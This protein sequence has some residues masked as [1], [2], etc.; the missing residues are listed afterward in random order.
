MNKT[1]RLQVLRK[2]KAT[3]DAARAV[4][5]EA[6]AARTAAARVTRAANKEARLQAI[7]AGKAPRGS[8]SVARSR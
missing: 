5:A 8:V 3:N 2:I 7:Y 1:E 4:R 6:I